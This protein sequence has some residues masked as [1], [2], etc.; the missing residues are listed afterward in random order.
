MRVYEY[1]ALRQNYCVQQR[2]CVL[3][4][5]RTLRPVPIQ[6]WSANKPVAVEQVDTTQATTQQNT[7]VLLLQRKC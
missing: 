5:A 4:R 1:P 7:G 6:Q 3:L 2:E